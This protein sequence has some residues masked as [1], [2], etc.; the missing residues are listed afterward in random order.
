M[1]ETNFGWVFEFV[2][3]TYDASIQVY[4]YTK[5]TLIFIFS[6]NPSKPTSKPN[7]YNIMIPIC[8]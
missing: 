4:K 5:A 8:T 1:V 3:N 2:P 7:F 6:K